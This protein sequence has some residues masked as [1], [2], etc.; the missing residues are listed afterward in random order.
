LA[1]KG[2]QQLRYGERTARGATEGKP[3]AV[4]LEESR[5]VRSSKK[6]MVSRD[7]KRKIAVFRPSTT[8]APDTGREPDR[9]GGNDRHALHARVLYAYIRVTCCVLNQSRCPVCSRRISSA[10]L[11]ETIKPQLQYRMKYEDVTVGL[12]LDGALNLR[13]MHGCWIHGRE[14]VDTA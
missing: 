7:T 1:S 6:I 10:K 3:E 8:K 9:E 11:R 2:S 12:W 13:Q 14:S 5:R 4:T